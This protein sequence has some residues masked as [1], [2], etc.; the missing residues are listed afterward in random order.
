M[1]GIVPLSVDLLDAAGARQQLSQL[2]DVTH[3]VFGAFMLGKT[4]AETSEVNVALLR[5]LLDAVEPT[6]PTLRHITFYQG[7]SAYGAQ[8]GPFK[9]PAREDDPRLM[10][11]NVYYNQED[12]L[13]E[14]QKGKGW[15][16]TALRPESTTGF[17]IGNPM[18]LG[19]LIAA[20]AVIC[21]QLGLPLRY[22]GSEQAYHALHQITSSGLLGR[23]TVWAG[24]TAAARNEIF[25]VTNGDCFRF[26]HMWPRIARMFDM[27]VAS[28]VPISLANHMADKGPVWDA[29]VR[30]YDLEPIPYERLALWAFG[31]A[32]LHMEF[33]NITS[34]VKARRAGFH[35]CIDTEEMFSALFDELRARRVIPALGKA[36]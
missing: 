10:G 15:F 6:S 25:N 8:L 18:N 7:G 21:K 24:T 4:D 30:R 9:T 13:R 36:A 35:D 16:W 20:Y 12:F 5:N 33:D 31:D 17:A 28:P 11:P 23:A 34:T 19:M 1:S 14:R 26:V 27:E 29:I 3:I 32:Q 2:R 22:P